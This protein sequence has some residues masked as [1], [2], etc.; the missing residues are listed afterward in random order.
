VSDGVVKRRSIFGNWRRVERSFIDFS[1]K[2][3]LVDTLLKLSSIIK[4]SLVFKLVA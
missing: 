3:G 4:M 2:I 1:N